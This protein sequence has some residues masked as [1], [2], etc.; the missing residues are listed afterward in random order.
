[1]STVN[2]TGKQGV[3]FMT[4]R[5]KDAKSE[6]GKQQSLGGD[7]FQSKQIDASWKYGMAWSIVR[8]LIKSRPKLFGK[9]VRG[10]KEGSDWEDSFEKTY[11]KT[12]DE[13]FT[14]YARSI[15]MPNLKP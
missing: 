12:A 15:G 8:F 1:W 10:I 7:F 2:I 4:Q 13:F 5:L 14:A 11:G 9:F 6:L 3:E